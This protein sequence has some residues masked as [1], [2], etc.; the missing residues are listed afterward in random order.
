MKVCLQKRCFYQ[1]VV[2]KS[3]FLADTLKKYL[4]VCIARVPLPFNPGDLVLLLV[5]EGVEDVGV[6]PDNHVLC[7]CSHRH[8]R[9]DL[10]WCEATSQGRGYL[11]VL[12]N[13]QSE[14]PCIFRKIGWLMYQ[15]YLMLIRLWC[16]ECRDPG[17]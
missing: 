3:T 13:T 4:Y 1:A 2:S 17:C 15:C 8:A 9:S 14:F 10:Y 16:A 11:T 5:L 7:H 12:C 6:V